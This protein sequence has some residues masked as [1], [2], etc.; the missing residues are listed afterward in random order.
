L[1]DN[2][3]AEASAA[4]GGVYNQ[5]DA[6]GCAVREVGAESQLDFQCPLVRDHLC[7]AFLGLA[8]AFFAAKQPSI[9]MQSAENAIT[10]HG[11]ASEP[12]QGFLPH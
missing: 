4:L 5:I 10:Q 11:C 9:A 12:F 8:E 3:R 1:L 2:A 7:R 6:G